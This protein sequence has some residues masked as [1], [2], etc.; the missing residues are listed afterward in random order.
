MVASNRPKHPET[1]PLIKLSLEI[2]AMAISPVMAKAVYSGGANLRATMARRGANA[3]STRPP[4]NPPSAD[5]EIAIPIASAARP[6]CA[7]GYPSI[8][9]AAAS[10][11]PGIRNK[12]AEMEPPQEPPTKIAI[13]NPI[14]ANGGRVIATGKSKIIPMRGP[15]PG[16]APTSRPNNTPS[17]VSPMASGVKNNSNPDVSEF[18]NIAVTRGC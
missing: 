1:S 18:K 13:R 12:I 6:F 2:T 16:R 11:V 4:K 9:V 14:A 8:R 5:A 3:I 10:G 15:R 17:N 7:I